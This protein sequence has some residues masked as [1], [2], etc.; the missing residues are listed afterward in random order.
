MAMRVA[1][2]GGTLGSRLRTGGL[3]VAGFCLGLAA[4]RAPVVLLAGVLASV[5]LVVASVAE[6]LAGLSAALAVGPFRAWLEIWSP[7]IAPYAGQAVLTIV[8][9][10][11]LARAVWLRESSLLLPPLA[12]TLGGFLFVGLLSLLEPH[13]LWVGF[14]EWIKWVQVLLVMLLVFDRLAKTGRHGVLLAV[15]GLAGAAIVQA[16]I[17]LW[18]FGLRGDGVEP[19]LIG[20]RFYRAYGTFQQ[21]NPYAGLLGLVGA[22]LMGIALS[23]A[24]DWWRAGRRPRD[25]GLV[26]GA[27]AL[28]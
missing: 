24:A 5:A 19:F 26:V 13:D 4:A 6:P 17:G 8:L 28:A 7:G 12:W 23:T 9:V 3:L 20:G 21:P 14:L 2:V 25:L 15:A 1:Q 16:L 27:A 22:L 18:Q 10:A 11:W